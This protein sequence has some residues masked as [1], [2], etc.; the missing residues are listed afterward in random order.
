MEKKLRLRIKIGRE[1]ST[2]ILFISINLFFN[3]KKIAKTQR[4]SYV[5]KSGRQKE[6]EHARIL[7]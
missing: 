4:F 1:K 7:R 3:E 5:S 2:A 6:T